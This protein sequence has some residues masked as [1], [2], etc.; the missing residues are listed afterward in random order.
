MARALLDTFRQG[1]DAFNQGD[2]VTLGALFDENVALV[3]IDHPNEQK[4]GKDEVLM[5]I[6]RKIGTDH[7]K[8][9]PVP[10]LSMNELAGTIDGTAMWEDYDL[11]AGKRSK[12]VLPIKFRFGFVFHQA[13]QSWY[14]VS[15]FGTP[16]G[17]AR[18]VP[19]PPN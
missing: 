6:E 15:L 18:P 4:Q 11:V 16:D 9:Y 14:F 8:F 7:P 13:D 19:T 1:C 3:T 2:Y 17:S 12:T 5:Y 10:P